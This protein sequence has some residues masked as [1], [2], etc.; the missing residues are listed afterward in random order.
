MVFLKNGKILYPLIKK[1][2]SK[3]LHDR[4][5]SLYLRCES[6]DKGH[7][8][9]HFRMRFATGVHAYNERE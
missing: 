8:K 7:V 2:L 6:R 4:L 1:N 3:K 9:D 5:L